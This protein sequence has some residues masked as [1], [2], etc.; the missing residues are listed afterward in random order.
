MKASLGECLKNMK[1]TEV[2]KSYTHTILLNIYLTIKV[3]RVMDWLTHN[4]AGLKLNEPVN[5]ALASFFQY[6]IH[7]WKS[8]YPYG[9]IGEQ[10]QKEVNKIDL[11]HPF[12]LHPNRHHILCGFKHFL[13]SF[14]SSHP[15]S[16]E[17][18]LYCDGL[19]AA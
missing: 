6:H 12:L 15:C 16:V 17:V 11:Y 3:S 4:P 19:S 8:N 13:H 5:R 2:L 7:L 9:L 1:L 10:I 18:S 14:V